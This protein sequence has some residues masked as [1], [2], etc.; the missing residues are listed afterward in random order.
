MKKILIYIGLSFGMPLYLAAQ[1]IVPVQKETYLLRE[2]SDTQFSSAQAD[3]ISK[4]GFNPYSL[5]LKPAKRIVGR[6]MP[7]GVNLTEN[8]TG[9]LTA[10]FVAS[11]GQGYFFESFESAYGSNL[12]T[13]WSNHPSAAHANN[14]AFYWQAFSPRI[15][16]NP[17]PQNRMVMSIEGLLS[18]QMYFD[19][20]LQSPEIEILPNSVLSFN[21][22]F[23]PAYLCQID[24]GK[25][26]FDPNVKNADL[27]I[28]VVMS[29]SGNSTTVFSLFDASKNDAEFQKNKYRSYSADLSAFAG[30]KV[31]FEFCYS[32]NG[33]P[34]IDLDDIGIAC[35][36]R[37]EMTLPALYQV[38]F[39][40]VCTDAD[41]YEWSFTGSGISKSEE[42]TPVVCFG[43][44]GKASVTLKMTKGS[45]VQTYTQNL[46]IGEPLPAIARYKHPDGV[47]LI[48]TYESKVTPDG[49]LAPT[50]VRFRMV[51]KSLFAGSYEWNSGSDNLI[52]ENGN[53]DT[54]EMVSYLAS[55]TVPCPSLQVS[56]VVSDS[57]YAHS[58]NLYLGGNYLVWNIEN[59]IG[60]QNG[61][62][63]Q[64][65]G[66][67]SVY[68][69]EAIS[70]HYSR[71]L[72]EQFIGGVLLH[73]II[74]QSTTDFTLTATLRGLDSGNELGR[75]SVP[76]SKASGD[77][78]Y[79]AFFIF[80]FPSL[81]KITEPF[82]IEISGIPNGENEKLFF[83]NQ[84]FGINGGRPFEDNTTYFKMKG[85]WIPAN[86]LLGYAT[87][88]SISPLIISPVKDI[89][90]KD[91]STGHYKPYN[92]NRLQLNDTGG[93][94]NMGIIST[95]SLKKKPETDAGWIRC[96]SMK[97]ENNLNYLEFTY[98]SRNDGERKATIHITDSLGIT[99]DFTVYQGTYTTM[100]VTSAV[101]TTISRTE[102]KMIVSN[103]LPEDRQVIIYDICG[104]IIDRI[105]IKTNSIEWRLPDPGSLYLIR[106]EGTKSRNYKI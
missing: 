64:G 36:D 43:S 13:G 24:Y 66:S 83:V 97:M 76:K 91:E 31:H 9:E 16:G 70:E 35:T 63:M 26:T 82:A 84:Y 33:V 48:N 50:D 27:E 23:N 90:L 55:N 53:S 25:G 32:G 106:I 6:N 22:G 61:R 46:T 20:M 75:S 72:K 74:A 45:E 21:V 77:G 67:N 62:A 100:S 30:R 95:F 81:I 49:Y 65:L 87:S 78:S 10:R 4:K 96:T 44:E 12:P 104:R 86:D 51:D 40:P 99:K 102:N 56:N 57:T 38:Q 92:L 89:Y 1:Q 88:L 93:K 69:F 3:L 54:S 58:G 37:Q 73:F 15:P 68:Q 18:D 39:T 79:G 98:D 8:K 42:R 5:S 2:S 52:L 71:P 11:A 60:G 41:H 47:Y 80:N 28:N 17:D 103:L 14:I 19:E 7:V 94:L 59:E 85:A 34:R 101:Q 29:D 105:H